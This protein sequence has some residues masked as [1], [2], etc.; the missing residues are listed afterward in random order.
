MLSRKFFTAYCSFEGRN[1]LET[2]M[3]TARAFTAFGLA[4]NAH[5]AP[6]SDY[7]CIHL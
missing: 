6:G 7:P 4:Q 2:M 1:S 5:K 3:V